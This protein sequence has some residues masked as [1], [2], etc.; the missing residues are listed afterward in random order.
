MSGKRAARE[1]RIVLGRVE[2]CRKGADRVDQRALGKL[3]ESVESGYGR[4]RDLAA[5]SQIDLGRE[6]LGGCRGGIAFWRVG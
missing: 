1:K 3:R 5:C 2:G 4:I 6:A